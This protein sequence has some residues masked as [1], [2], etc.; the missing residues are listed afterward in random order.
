MA[1]SFFALVSLTL[2]G[3]G[4]CRLVNRNHNWALGPWIEMG[5]GFFVSA[6][7]AA[8][9]VSSAMFSVS[10]ASQIVAT[11]SAAIVVVFLFDSNYRET[12]V[13]LIDITPLTRSH[14]LLTLVILGYLLLIFLNNVFRDIFPW[15]AFTT[16]IY[17][18]KAW[19][20]TNQ[21]SSFMPINQWL[22]NDAAGFSIAAAHYPI[23]VSAIA[24]FSASVSGV[25]SDQ[26]ASLPWFFASCAS[27]MV[28]FGLCRFQTPHSY[29]SPL[30]ACVMLTTS[31]LVHLH[32]ALAG[33]ADIWV[34]GTSGMGLAGLCLWSQ[35]R[36]KQLLSISFLLL[37]L[38]C[39]WKLEG[40][41]W[42]A[43]GLAAFSAEI[44]GRRFCVRTLLAVPVILTIIWI[45]QPV[46]LGML[47]VWGVTNN[48][49]QFGPLGSFAMLPQNPL[50]NYVEMTFWRTNFLLAMPLYLAALAVLAL[51]QRRVALVFLLMGVGIA[52]IHFFI[53][54]LSPYS[55]FAQLGTATNRVLL[56]TLPVFIVTII[57]AGQYMWAQLNRTGET[58]VTP[59]R[60]KTYGVTLAGLALAA[61]L[62]LV[63]L[64]V[65]AT[66]DETGTDGKLHYDASEL[67]AVVGKWIQGEQG[68]QFAGE[69]VPIGV[70]KV[71]LASPG[72]NPPRYLIAE[73]WMASPETVSF[74]WINDETPRVHSIPLIVSGYSVI[75]MAGHTDFWRHSVT[76]MGYLVEPIHFDVSGVRSLTFSST[77]FDASKALLRHWLTPEQLSHRLINTT[78][79]HVDA[80]VTLQQWF[81]SA[82]FFLCLLGLGWGVWAHSARATFLASL[83]VAVGVLWLLGAMAHLNQMLAITTPLLETERD[84]ADDSTLAAPHIAALAEQL[85][86]QRNPTDQ[87]ILTVGIDPAGKLHAERLPFMLLPRRAIATRDELLMTIAGGWS[88]DLVVLGEDKRLRNELIHRIQ[89]VS[90]LQPIE[91]GK[92]FVLLSARNM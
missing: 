27:C 11:V 82:F 30:I 20:T 41:V 29:W 48:V 18:A 7:I 17:R 25:W 87:P 26:T 68:F 88:G 59:G 32:G 90:Q 3:F 21:A 56:Q 75:D 71:P 54:G 91:S 81:T 66:G 49:F 73:S 23:S 1:V 77:L 35:R 63:M 67:R 34:M 39:M 69:N 43:L 40:W 85:K 9:F 62:P 65:E 80:P 72:I 13:A 19:V 45:L 84:R 46:D 22:A 60:I 36:E 92:D 64:T 38:G 58:H 52:C 14:V 37:G 24:A 79:G 50:W 74:Y 12:L 42:L 33:Y 16:W 47:G 6:A 57:A 55:H 53:F 8:F 5:A 83:A 2:L 70:A 4:V 31:P 78:T 61:T 28:L 10:Q 86:L 76:E 15:D 44:V 51:W 89:R